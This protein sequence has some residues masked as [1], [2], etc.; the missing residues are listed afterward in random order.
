MTAVIFRGPGKTKVAVICITSIN[1]NPPQK[2]QQPG[3]P[4][5]SYFFR[6]L[7]APKTSI[8]CLQKWAQT[9]FQESRLPNEKG[10]FNSWP[11]YHSIVGLVTSP[12]SEVRGHVNSASLLRVTFPQKSPGI[13]YVFQGEWHIFQGLFHFG[14]RTLTAQPWKVVTFQLGT[15]SSS[16]TSKAPMFS[17]QLPRGCI[18]PIRWS[19]LT[20]VG[21]MGGAPVYV[22]ADGIFVGKADFAERHQVRL[23]AWRRHVTSDLSP[24]GFGSPQIG[25]SKNRGTLKWMVYSGKPY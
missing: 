6:Q 2:N 17:V 15:G 20:Q 22:E 23:N 4:S 12:T 21:R 5:V 25:V 18:S 24:P 3:T 11:F 9:A 10:W 13:S 8:Y 1:L 7:G 16:P 14:S 19:R